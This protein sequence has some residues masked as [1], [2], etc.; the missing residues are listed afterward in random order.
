MLAA[1]PGTVNPGPSADACRGADQ[2][3]GDQHG[4]GGVRLLA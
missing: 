2:E 1:A 3:R 4:V